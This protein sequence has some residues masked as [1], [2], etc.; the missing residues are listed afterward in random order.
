MAV[1]DGSESHVSGIR[2]PLA[3]DELARI[4][5]ALE[6]VTEPFVA[7]AGFQ[8]PW[9]AVGG[10]SLLTLDDMAGHGPGVR[11]IHTLRL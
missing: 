3:S 1:T 11:V 9:L 7:S 10:G 5:E 6:S 2:P 4:K 8:V